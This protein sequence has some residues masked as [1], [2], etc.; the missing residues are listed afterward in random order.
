MA[1]GTVMCTVFLE[2]RNPRLRDFA[3]GA[4]VRELR[5]DWRVEVIDAPAAVK[6]ETTSGVIRITIAGS[7]RWMAV[8]WP[9]GD[10]RAAASALA[11]GAAAVVSLGSDSAQ[12]DQALRVTAEG[13]DAHVSPE[14]VRGLARELL[15]QRQEPRSPA[16]M[17]PHLTKREME[18]LQLVAA[19]LNN[20][21]I[22]DRL[23]LSVNTVRSHLQTLSTK[24]R[25]SSR[26]KMVANAWGSGLYAQAE[27]VAVAKPVAS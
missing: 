22:A 5:P 24:L 3:L 26:A 19:G 12:L 7:S 4:L 1:V 11:E 8:L 20:R 15:A 23:T 25:A 9:E 10:F 6:T 27:P 16:T 13:G 2:S 21:E 17:T 18:V 14:L